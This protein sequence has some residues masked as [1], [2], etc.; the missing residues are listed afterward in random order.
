MKAL[1]IGLLF[2]A[3]LS[4]SLPL[5]A[6][7]HGGGGKNAEQRMDQLAVELDLTEAQEKAVRPILEDSRDQRRAVLDA[8]GVGKGKGRPDRDAMKAIR[9]EMK[10]ISL[11]TDEQLAGILSAEQMEK[12]HQIR[13]EARAKMRERMRAK[14]QQGEQQE[15][16]QGEQPEA[17]PGAQ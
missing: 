12:F 17:V 2:I 6:G 4:L 8:H 3:T 15:A 13:K 16:V 11:E 14:H 7:Q 9:G 5:C 1:K 10:A